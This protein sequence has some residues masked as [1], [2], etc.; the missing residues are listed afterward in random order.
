VTNGTRTFVQGSAKSP[1]GRRWRDLF[2]LHADD[3]GP[4]DTLSQAQLSLCKKAATIEVELEQMTGRLS[5][6]EEVDLDLF[7]RGVG[8]L[9]RIFEVLGIRRAPRDVTSLDAYLEMRGRANL[10]SAGVP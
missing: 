10:N 7:F 9:R 3:L 1:W 8:H 5:L 2:E 6:G 4:Q